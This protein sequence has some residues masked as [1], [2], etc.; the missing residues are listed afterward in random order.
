[1]HI[2][3]LI[4]KNEYETAYDL[5][6]LKQFSEPKIY[7]GKGD[8]S[9]RWYV[10]FS[11]RNPAT[12][13]LERQPPIYGEANKLKNKTDRLSYL[14]TIRKVLHR[15]L[16][17]GYSPFED[18]RETDKRLAEESKAASTKK[19][20]NKRVQS[21]HQSYTVKQA[22]EFALAQKQPS[23]SKRT[24]STFTGHY[25]KFM[26]WLEGNKLSSLDISELKKRD[27]SLFLN[28]L[29]KSQTKKEKLANAPIE[30][31]SPKTK[32]N[33]KA[34][35]SILFS[36]LEDD[37]IIPY[38]FVE[39][40]KN[41]K[42]KPKKNKPFS[43]EQIIAIREYLDKNDPYLRVFMQFMSYAFLRNI[44]V[45]RL[46][47]KDIDLKAKRLYVRSKTSPLAVVPII[48]ELENII[49][50]MNLERYA[51]TDYLIT[52]KN[53]PFAWD[54]DENTKTKH[55]AARFRKVK[56]ALG[57][58]A[59]YTLYSTRHTAATNL[60][61]HLLSEGNSEEEALMKLMQITRHKSKAGLK[62]YL[63]EIGATLPKDYGDMYTIEF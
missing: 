38:N 17:E 25:N 51:P 20:S 52:R 42:T 13:K 8:L 45:C 50:R 32:N 48:G 63:R 46:Q 24:A 22:M 14:S 7:T 41:V 3:E 36:Q 4:K 10:Y 34:T 39:K 56:K 21:Q 37:E 57:L 61:N 28:T 27:V 44:E 49:R 23:W 5:K 54:I 55:F 16:K 60:Y 33:Y 11:Y 31:V 43:K 59:D 47:V 2:L 26:Q 35:L 19:Q 29:K 18:A 1:M 30:V 58:G 12:G 40:I 53:E 62:N 15:M 9:K 6:K